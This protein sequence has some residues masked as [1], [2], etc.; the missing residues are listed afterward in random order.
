MDGMIQVEDVR[1]AKGAVDSSRWRRRHE[2]GS[3]GYH[4][5]DL[6]HVAHPLVHA[7]TRMIGLVANIVNNIILQSDWLRGRHEDG[8]AAATAE[9]VTTITAW[10]CH[11]FMRTY[12]T[13]G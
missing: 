2:G 4:T 8:V 1:Y 3:D 10:V 6:T 11:R 13:S 7:L 5:S 12:A 9:T